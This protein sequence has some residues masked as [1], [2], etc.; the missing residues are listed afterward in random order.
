MAIPDVSGKSIAELISL[1]DRNAVVTGGARGIGLAIC[2][3][4]AEAGANV[5]IGDLDEKQAQEAAERIAQQHGVSMIATLL[6]VADSGSIGAV[7]TQA[8]RELG[9]VDIWGRQVGPGAGY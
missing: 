4:F 6:D 1:K 9:G 5:L 2:E 7:A 8:V 3:R